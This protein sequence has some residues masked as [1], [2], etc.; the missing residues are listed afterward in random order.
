MLK[1]ISVTDLRLGMHLHALE[2]SWLDHPFWRS[3]FVLTDMADLEAVRRSGSKQCWI[4]V[5][6]GLDVDV[7]D[8]APPAQPAPQR[9]A[10]VPSPAPTVRATAFPPEPSASFD[11]EIIRAARLCKKSKQAVQQLFGD[12]RM[13][14]ALDPASTLPLVEELAA[15]VYRNPGALVSLTRLKT[16]DDYSY[17]HSVAVC[18]LMVALGRTLGLSVEECRDAGMAGLLHDVGKALMPLDVLNKPGKLSEA[19]FT[20]MR[21]H[22]ERGHALLAE[23]GGAGVA[24]LD[25]CLHH[26]ER[27]DGSGYPHR[28]KAE[29]ISQ[30]A[31]MGA[32]CDVYDAISSQRPYKA[33]WDPA[34]S[35][36]RMASWHGHFDTALFATFVRSL[37][38]YPTGSLVRLRSGRLAVVVTQHP[39]NLTAPTVKAFFSVKSNM[40]IPVVSIDLGRPETNDAIVAREPRAQ[41]NFPHLDTLWAGDSAPR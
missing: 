41:W 22:P 4:D 35:I 33:A 17:M 7:P 9:P 16:K 18:A 8:H 3:K 25:V 23:S 14:K 27:I 36:A 1:K 28:L 32:I 5:S 21:T 37:G 39:Q 11:E 24:A 20:V 19:E 30:L 6:K 12:L 40:P 13:G 34:D 29:Q 2:A 26:H 31:R 15:S 10:T 38:I